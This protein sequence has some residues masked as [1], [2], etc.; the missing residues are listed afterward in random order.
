M[1]KNLRGNT[2]AVTDEEVRLSIEI[3]DI[4]TFEVPRNKRFN[5]LERY[6]FRTFTPLVRRILQQG[7]NYAG[8]P[9][10]LRDEHSLIHTSISISK[11]ES[12]GGSTIL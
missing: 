5:M 1:L 8:G 4:K 3:H 7:V 11:Q 2:R 12:L 10:A 9:L 6:E